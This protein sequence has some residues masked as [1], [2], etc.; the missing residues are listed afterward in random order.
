ML[1]LL[2]TDEGVF[3]LAE[4]AADQPKDGKQF[5]DAVPWNGPLLAQ[6]GREGKGDPRAC[7]LL[8][9]S[10]CFGVYKIYTGDMG[11]NLVFIFTGMNSVRG[12]GFFS[13]VKK[14]TS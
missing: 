6:Q 14:I 4:F 5:C 3:I 9:C 7:T 8:L 2:E 1:A 12:R 13:E 10:L 11:K